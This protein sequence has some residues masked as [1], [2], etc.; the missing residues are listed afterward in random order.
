MSTL[1]FK[2]TI[3]LL[4][5][6]FSDMRASK[7]WNQTVTIG[8]SLQYSSQTHPHYFR[9]GQNSVLIRNKL[10]QWWFLLLCS[11]HTSGCSMVLISLVLSFDPGEKPQLTNELCFQCGWELN[12]TTPR[13]QHSYHNSVFTENDVTA[14]KSSELSHMSDTLA[15]L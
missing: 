2:N 12:S 9:K 1:S 4:F 14:T 6:F 7:K 15:S 3:E 5:V 8:R 10:T 11:Y 13:S